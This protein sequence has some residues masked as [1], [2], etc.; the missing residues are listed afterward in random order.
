M[1]PGG[2]TDRS[3]LLAAATAGA[4]GAASPVT[5]TVCTP[6]ERSCASSAFESG[7]GGSLRAA[8]PVS[9]GRRRGAPAVAS[10]K[11]PT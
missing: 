3:S 10:V 1:V 6:I 8:N 7:G 4:V 11:R 2:Q 5:V 9:A